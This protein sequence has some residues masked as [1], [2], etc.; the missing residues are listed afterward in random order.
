MLLESDILSPGVGVEMVIS[1]PFN[2]N[3]THVLIVAIQ[4]AFY[5]KN[6]L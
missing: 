5:Y 1:H 2:P 6:S 3:E 4:H